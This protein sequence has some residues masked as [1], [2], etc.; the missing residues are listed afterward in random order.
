M[1]DGSSVPFETQEGAETPLKRRMAVAFGD[2]IT[3]L[4]AVNSWGDVGYTFGGRKGYVKLTGDYLF[5]W[6]KPE[7]QPQRFLRKIFLLSDFATNRDP[8]PFTEP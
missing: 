1:S 5:A 8:P 4:I 3:S 2:N 7:N 6:H